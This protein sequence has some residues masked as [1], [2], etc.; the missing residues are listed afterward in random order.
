[1]GDVDIFPGESTSRGTTDIGILSSLKKDSTSA[2][3]TREVDLEEKD[4]KLPPGQQ[5]PGAVSHARCR[6]IASGSGL[7][8]LLPCFFFVIRPPAVM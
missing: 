7:G 5:M 1:V 3:I 6:R 4:I 2:V 8:D